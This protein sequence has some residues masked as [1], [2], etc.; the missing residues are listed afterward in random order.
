VLLVLLGLWGQPVLLARQV[1]RDHLDQQDHPMYK[2]L[3]RQSQE[4]STPSSTT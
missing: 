2:G 4:R 1:S 3:Q